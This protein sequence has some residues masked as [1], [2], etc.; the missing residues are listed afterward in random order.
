MH[1]EIKVICIGKTKESYLQQGI[2]KYLERISHYVT[3][4]LF[5]LKPEK[6]QKL[7]EK[8][9]KL[10]QGYTILLDVFGQELS[11][12]EF[13]TLIQEK[14]NQ[15][16]PE[17]DFL[18]GGYSGLPTLPEELIDLRISLSRCTFTHQLIRLLLLE[19]VYR[20]FTIMKGHPY[21]K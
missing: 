16:C 4:Q 3:I 9:R 11:S 15:G 8:T 20:S 13:A 10:I 6:N 1:M 5:E 2:R 14:I 12:E 7:A 21:H 19:Q 18:I 17:I